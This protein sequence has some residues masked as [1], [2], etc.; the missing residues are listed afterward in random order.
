MGAALAGARTGGDL[1]ATAVARD[2]HGDYYLTGHAS[3]TVLMGGVWL[4]GRGEKQA[5]V[6][7]LGPDCRCRRASAL[8][9]PT[10]RLGAGQSI[11]VDGT[12]HVWVSGS[13]P[14]RPI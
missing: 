2:R 8:P 12:G 14:I 10:G 4:R 11:A 13:M 3:G 9:T 7:R 6:A 5:F 1:T